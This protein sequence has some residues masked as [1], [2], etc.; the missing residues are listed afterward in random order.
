M[1]SGLLASL[2]QTQIINILGTNLKINDKKPSF[3]KTVLKHSH[4]LNKHRAA[5]LV[6]C[7]RLKVSESRQKQVMTNM[8]E[9]RIHYF[10]VALSRCFITLCVALTVNKTSNLLG[11]IH[12]SSSPPVAQISTEPGF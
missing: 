1:D 10:F 3:Y 4:Y 6:R 7:L 9:T 5:S 11:L 12:H 8:C 2:S